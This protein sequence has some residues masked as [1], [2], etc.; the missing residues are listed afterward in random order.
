MQWKKTVIVTLT[1]VLL[2]A[3]AYGFV[4]AYIQRVIMIA[5]QVTQIGKA[6]EQIRQF[7]DKLDRMS[8]QIAMVKDLKDST[9]GELGALKA[10]F[11]SLVST[12]TELVGDT[13]SWGSDFQGEARDAFNA[14]RSFGRDARSLRESWRGKLSAADQVRESDIL[15]L[16]R[17][18]SPEDT[19]KALELWRRERQQADTQLVLDHTVA[20]AAAALAKTLKDAQTSIDKLRNQTNKSEKALQQ[21]QV[22]GIATQGEVLLSLAQLQAWQAARETAKSYQDEVERRR[23]QAHQIAKE[24]EHAA[25]ADKIYDEWAGSGERLHDLLML[26]TYY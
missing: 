23:R 10:E 12:P 26:S 15:E 14:A 16:Y 21:A 25:E 9:I 1:L 22:T 5:Q 17:N 8:E 13:M 18:L 7:K 6:T 2:A 11:T 4:A 20:D 19:Q 24:K 3:P